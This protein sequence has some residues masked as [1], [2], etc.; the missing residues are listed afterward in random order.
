M[1]EEDCE[2]F[3]DFMSLTFAALKLVI[4]CRVLWQFVLDMYDVGHQGLLRY[5]PPPNVVLDLLI[6]VSDDRNPILE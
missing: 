2:L 5:L 6:A 4:S 1:F 3:E